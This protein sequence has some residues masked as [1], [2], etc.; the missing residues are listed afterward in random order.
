MGKQNENRLRTVLLGMDERAQTAL[1]MFLERYCQD[2]VVLVREESAE[3]SVIDM[4]VMRGEQL[5]Q[6]TRKKYPDRPVILLS[7][8]KQIS[9]GMFSVEKPVRPD[10]MVSVL[11]Q[12]TNL[13]AKGASSDSSNQEDSQND[14]FSA[15]RFNSRSYS[16]LERRTHQVALQFDDRRYSAVRKSVDLNDQEQVDNMHFNPKEYLLG[17]VLSAFRIACSE[18]RVLRLETGWK[19]II[20]VPD[21]QRVWVDADDKQLRS[22]A[23]V[24]TLSVSSIA[25]DFRGKV[26]DVLLSPVSKTEKDALDPGSFQTM[27]AFLWKLALWTA[28]GRV[29]DNIDFKQPVFLSRWPNF[30]RCLISPHALRISALLVR[31]PRTLSDL[32][33]VLNIRYDYALSFFTAAYALGF[34]GQ[35]KQQS[36]TIVVQPQPPIKFR[37]HT[38]I[39]SKILSR[40]RD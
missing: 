27:E 9:P 24:P 2:R 10:A 29:P 12:V 31:G 30:T 17:S 13:L 28:N 18:N 8:G 1:G 23:K 19:P 11:K 15:L 5:F 25:A 40:L 4:D 36:D 34:A 38:G 26:S 3:V 21:T 22:V 6:E 33:S 16:G 32:A 39:L 37:K 20:I 7:L 14:G 35:A